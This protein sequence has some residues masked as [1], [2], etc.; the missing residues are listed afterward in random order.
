M[1][2]VNLFYKKSG[3]GIPLIILHGL[4]GSLDNW[5]GIVKM[6]EPRF[7]VYVIDQRNH[8]RSPRIHEH[9]YQAMAA[10]LLAFF[11]A[12]SINKAIIIGH[13]MGGKT[14]MLFSLLH[15][16][17]VSRLIVVDIAPKSYLNIEQYKDEYQDH[18]N[19]MQAI[20]MLDLDKIHS[21]KD[22]ETQLSKSISNLQIRKF[23]LKNIK[24]GLDRQNPYKLILNISAII[25][26]Q[27]DIFDWPGQVLQNAPKTAFPVLFLKG[28]KS[29]YIDTE[30]ASLIKV[31][32]PG[33]NIKTIGNA[34]HWLHFEQPKEF[35]KQVLEFIAGRM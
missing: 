27:N 24:H 11:N 9:T 10:D 22:A 3:K 7:E 19:I 32:F 5:A 33:S 28:E 18:Q 8:G 6:F 34:S 16:E 14:A 20:N 4:Y 35:T 26:Y 15:P 12:H 1:E 13:S 2:T 29:R 21:L 30:D 25:N 31:L 23:I 17:K